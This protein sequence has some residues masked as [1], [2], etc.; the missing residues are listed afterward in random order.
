MRILNAQRG[1]AARAA[2]ESTR[3]LRTCA[4]D[5]EARR[6]PKKYEQRRLDGSLHTLLETSAIVR[7]HVNIAAPQPKAEMR[8]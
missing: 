7:N 2:R 3:H 1:D 5:E 6:R 8:D 4:R